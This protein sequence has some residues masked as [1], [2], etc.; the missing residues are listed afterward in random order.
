[1]SRPGVIIPTLGNRASLW[2]LVRSV[3]PDTPVV[4]VWTGPDPQAPERPADEQR[5]PFWEATR[6][7]NGVWGRHVVFFR[8]TLPI[9]IHRWWYKGAEIA[10][11]AGADQLVFCNDDVRAAPGELELLASYVDDGAQLAYL[12]RPEHAAVRPT[13]ITGWCFATRMTGLLEPQATNHLNDDSACCLHPRQLRWWYGDH[14]VEI[15]AQSGPRGR[16]AVLAVSGLDIEHLRTDWHYD[17][18]DEVNPL[19]ARDKRIWLDRWA[20]RLEATP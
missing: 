2:P 15:M 11:S 16:D 14:A 7:A 19:I 12:D 9:D 8:D 20:H 17:R 3:G 6:R 1:V 18:P 13:A 5:W 10:G 4:I